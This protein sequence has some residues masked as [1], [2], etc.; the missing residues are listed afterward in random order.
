MQQCKAVDVID[1]NHAFVIRVDKLSLL[2]DAVS[3]RDSIDC[4]SQSLL[5]GSDSALIT[6]SSIKGPMSTFLK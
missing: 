4:C 1:N 6:L 2:S 5:L 3:Q